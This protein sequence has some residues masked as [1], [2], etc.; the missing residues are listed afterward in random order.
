MGSAHLGAERNVFYAGIRN[1]P[2]ATKWSRKD[3]KMNQGTTQNTPLRNRVEKVRKIWDSRCYPGEPFSSKITKNTIRKIIKQSISEKREI[4]YPKAANI[5]PESMQKLINKSCK[6]LARNRCGKSRTIVVFWNVKT[7]KS[8]VRVIR[9]EGFAR[10]VRE[11][12]NHQKTIN[13]YPNIHPKSEEKSTQNHTQ[14]K[15]C[16]KTGKPSKKGGR[17]E[18]KT[19]KNQSKTDSEIRSGK[20]RPAQPW[21]DTVLEE[22][23][24]HLSRNGGCG[25]YI[26]VCWYV[27][28]S[29]IIQT[30]C[31]DSKLTSASWFRI[32]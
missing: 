3:A 16:P 27:F 30:I 28:V 15:L 8:M 20:R 4:W 5:D 29:I 21:G 24:G 10:W 7:N 2:K 26:Y 11:R 25:E 12:A 19:I 31:F 32:G 6:N 14:K 17:R 9:F 23:A 22:V 13:N 1:M 18:S